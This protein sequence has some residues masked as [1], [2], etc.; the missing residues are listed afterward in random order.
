[1]KIWKMAVADPEFPRGG[2]AEPPGGWRQHTVLLK[3]PKNCMKLKEFE[4]GGRGVGDGGLA[5]IFTM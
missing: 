3:F 4:P 1:M 5:P 2:G